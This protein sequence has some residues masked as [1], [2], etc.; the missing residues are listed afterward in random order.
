MYVCMYV[1]MYVCKFDT[2]STYSDSDPLRNG[3]SG[4]VQNSSIAFNYPRLAASCVLARD[5]RNQIAE[6]QVKAASALRHEVAASINQG[7]T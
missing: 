5:R 3:F 7:L 4:R 2:N 6:S 1:S